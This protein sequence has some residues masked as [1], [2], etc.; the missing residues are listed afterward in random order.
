MMC[1]LRRVLRTH[2]DR[3][4]R[5]T[6]DKIY[7]R[8]RYKQLSVSPLHLSTANQPPHH[9][10]RKSGIGIRISEF[11]F[12]NSGFATWYPPPGIAFQNPIFGIWNVGLGFGLQDSPFGNR[13]SEFGIG[14]LRS[15]PCF[16]DLDTRS[17]VYSHSH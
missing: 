10:I 3:F 4:S 12:L 15:Q 11:V 16:H 1:G 5:C 6:E 17:D 2:R 13:S 8:N 14:D 9:E 7:G